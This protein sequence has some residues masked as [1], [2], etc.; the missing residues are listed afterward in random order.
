MSLTIEAFVQEDID[1]Q[2]N[3][4]LKNLSLA[5]YSNNKFNLDFLPESLEFLSISFDG[6]LS[7]DNIPKLD[8][9]PKSLKT[10]EIDFSSRPSLCL[11]N[12]NNNKIFINTIILKPNENFYYYDKVNLLN[13]FYGKKLV[14]DSNIP[15]RKMLLNSKFFNN[16]E[17]FTFTKI[18]NHNNFGTYSI[19]AGNTKLKININYLK[20][21]DIGDVTITKN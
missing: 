6:I 16:F 19:F 7:L 18:T 12:F 13:N 8:N 14:F 10:L 11:H 5:L 4:E 15:S 20:T 9:L 1:T 3:P 17:E 2:I 21:G